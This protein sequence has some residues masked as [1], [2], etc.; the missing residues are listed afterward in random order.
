MACCN[1]LPLAAA[2]DVGNSPLSDEYY[3]LRTAEIFSGVS[4]ISGYALIFTHSIHHLRL[5]LTATIKQTLNR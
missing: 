2:T 1:I 4:Q 5:S 3:M